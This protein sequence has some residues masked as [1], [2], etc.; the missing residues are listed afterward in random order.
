MPKGQLFRHSNYGGSRRKKNMDDYELELKARRDSRGRFEDQTGRAGADG[1]LILADALTYAAGATAF[2]TGAVDTMDAG[3]IEVRPMVLVVAG[4]GLWICSQSL[5]NFRRLLPVWVR[6][7]LRMKILPETFDEQSDFS[8]KRRMWTVVI[9]AA[10]TAIIAYI[11]TT[12]GSAV[13]TRSGLPFHYV[14]WAIVLMDLLVA[15]QWMRVIGRSDQI[16]QRPG[17]W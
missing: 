4:F 11:F 6:A 1:S 14:L 2:I 3:Q 16:G 9:A 13:I 15:I 7:L 10:L 8:R 5:N 12:D 17:G